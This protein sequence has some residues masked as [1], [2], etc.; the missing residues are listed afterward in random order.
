[1][2]KK[3]DTAWQMI[4]L[5]LLAAAMVVSLMIPESLLTPTGPKRVEISIL[6]RPGDSAVWATA[7]QGME[8]VSYTH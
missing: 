6:L 7:R 1:M 4:V 8:P 2:K 5:G 3:G